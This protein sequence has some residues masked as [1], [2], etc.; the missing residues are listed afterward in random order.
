MGE[1]SWNDFYQN[2]LLKGEVQEITIHSGVNRATAVLHQGAM[3][4][5]RKLPVNV[6]RFQTPQIDN[7]E[8]K[9][10]QPYSLEEDKS[11]INYF[12]EK[13]GVSRQ[14]GVA[15][16]KEMAEESIIPNRSWQSMK[17]R[18]DIVSKNLEVLPIK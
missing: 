8:T 4:Q 16:W 15:I 18:W 9:Q 10:R 5:G 14:K 3:Y 1:I 17:S 11:I 13:G 12:L 6:V 7:I 2:L